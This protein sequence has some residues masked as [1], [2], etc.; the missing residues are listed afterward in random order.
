MRMR[1]DLWQGCGYWQNQFIQQNILS[2]GYIAW[3]G[4]LNAGRGIVACNVM[5]TIPSSINW[6][7]DTATFHQVFI[8]QAQVEADLQVL[9][10]QPEVVT[11]VLNATATYDPT[12]VIVLLVSGNGVV[13]INLLENL[14][15]SP[16]D[17]Y[18]QVQHRWA[19]FQS[20]LTPQRRH[21]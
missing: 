21:S 5:D 16:A 4:Y 13:D 20:D 9:E 11:A 2:L 12:Q 3:N 17:C 1:N 15:I 19:E 8:P 7:V 10:L 14:K 6:E 18:A